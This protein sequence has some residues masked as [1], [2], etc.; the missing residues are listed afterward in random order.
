MWN[1]TEGT[2]PTLYLTGL[3]KLSHSNGKLLAFNAAFKAGQVVYYKAKRTSGAETGAF[4]EDLWKGFA[5][6]LWDQAQGGNAIDGDSY[7]C[8]Y[9]SIFSQVRP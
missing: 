4:N 5:Q 6:G 2:G 1:T 7:R 3:D 8:F 9:Y